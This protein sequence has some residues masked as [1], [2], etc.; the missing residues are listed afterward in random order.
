MDLCEL[1]NIVVIFMTLNCS[2]GFTP[3]LFQAR[4]SLARTAS[5][6]D[7]G[8]I[9]RQNEI[10]A[11]V[12]EGGGATIAT[13][14]MWNRVREGDVR[15]VFDVKAPRDINLAAAEARMRS[16]FHE[17]IDA[18]TVVPRM[19][20]IAELYAEVLN[21]SAETAGDYSTG[22]RC[23]VTVAEGVG[24]TAPCPKIHTDNVLLRC[25]VPISGPGTVYVEE[26]PNPFTPAAYVPTSPGDALLLKG[27]QWPSGRPA[28][29]RSPDPI[30]GCRVL[31]VLDRYQDVQ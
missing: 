2:E 12:V 23:R 14:E 27:R 15:V 3:T 29:H 25:I 20:D 17:A 26:S 22:I 28:K 8:L 19:L 9:L 1:I 11:A 16:L 13:R 18:K 5:W 4:E 30:D 6:S 31:L 21:L 10:S 7:A 24:R